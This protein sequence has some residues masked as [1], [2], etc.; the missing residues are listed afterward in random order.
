MWGEACKL[1]ETLVVETNWN[2]YKNICKFEEISADFGLQILDQ[3][4]Q[5]QLVI[6]E[7]WTMYDYYKSMYQEAYNNKTI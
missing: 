5:D 2:A 6:R 1:T 7:I 3:L 4:L